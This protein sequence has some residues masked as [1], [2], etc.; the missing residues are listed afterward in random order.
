MKKIYIGAAYYPEMWE[1]SEIEKDIQRCKETGINCLRIGEI[2][3]GKMEPKESEFDLPWLEKIVDKLYENGI[4]TV[5]CTPSATPP[6][7]LL[8]KYPERAR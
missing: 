5:M 2:R 7:W 4:Y 6:R 3:L 1:E 8:D